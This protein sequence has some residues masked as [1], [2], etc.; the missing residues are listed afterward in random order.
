MYNIQ[1]RKSFTTPKTWLHDSML[2]TIGKGTD[3]PGYCYLTSMDFSKLFK[4]Q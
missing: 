4:K 3:S 1:L 2:R